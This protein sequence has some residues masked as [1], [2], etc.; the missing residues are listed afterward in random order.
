MTDERIAKLEK[1][2]FV[3]DANEAAWTTRFVELVA[4]KQEHGDCNVPRN[5]GP[6]EQLGRW[7]FT[8]RYHYQRWNKG[9]KANITEARIAK[10]DAIEF[11]WKGK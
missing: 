9:K 1:I 10:L 6:N 8:Q 3:W 11:E 7:V 4:Y 5:Y 2:G